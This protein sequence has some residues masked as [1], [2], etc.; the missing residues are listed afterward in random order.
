[1]GE[2]AFTYYLDKSDLHSSKI[3]LSMINEFLRSKYSNVTF[4]CHNLGGYDIVYLLKVLFKHNDKHCEDKYRI[5]TLLRD[6][7][8][9]KVK[10]TKDKKSVTFL[11]SYAILP[12]SLRKL[13][14]NFQVAI[15]KSKFPYKFAKQDQLF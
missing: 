4:Y 6:D 12:N 9:I 1:M 7:K 8:I 5:S 13:G 3:V 14:E 10:I 15:L 2:D 11:D